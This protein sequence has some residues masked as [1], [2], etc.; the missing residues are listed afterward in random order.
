[1]I[2]TKKATYAEQKSPLFWIIM[3]FLSLFLVISPYYKGLFNGSFVF[4]ERSLY[5]TFI[6]A[7]IALFSV[8]LYVF[9]QKKNGCKSQL[10]FSTIVWLIPL[11]YVISMI[12]AKS[13][14]FGMMEIYLHITYAVFF[15]IGLYFAGNKVGSLILQAS[16]FLSSYA[17]VLYGLMNWLGFANYQ[18]AVLDNRLSGVFQYPN[19]YSGYLIGILLVCLIA[20]KNSKK[21]YGIILNG[22]MLGPIFLS[23]WLTLSRGGLF[24][25]PIV[26][27]IYL[28][29]I[30]WRQQLASLCYLAISGV[31]SLSAV[32][33]MTNLRL[34]IN[35]GEDI[36]TSINGCL[37]I[38]G[39]SVL[40]SVLVFVIQK[41]VILPWIQKYSSNKVFVPANFIIPGI[42]VVVGLISVI[43]L[44]GDGH[45]TKL[46]PDGL[47]TRIERINFDDRS[48]ASR[49]SYIADSMKIFKDYPLL[50][51]GGG[52]WASLY[53]EY[54]SFPYT[55]QQTHTF[56]LKYLI[57]TGIL[58]CGIFVFLVILIFV[59]YVRTKM[60]E[61]H[62]MSA[63]LSYPVLS[64]A[65]LV[66][67][68]IDFDM[69]FAYL[70]SLMFLGLGAM[71]S[72][73]H[74]Q[75]TFTTLPSKLRL[76]NRMF[77]LFLAVVALFLFV[78]GVKAI[79]AN[80][81]Y[82]R[83]MDI[84]NETGAVN[85]IIQPLD[86]AIEAQS[87][88]TYNLFKVDILVQLY[89]HTQDEQY[90]NEALNMLKVLEK[91]ESYNREMIEL[92]Y[93]LLVARREFQLALDW[94]ERNLKK[95]PWDIN[96]YE[97][98]IS[99]NYELG[100]E[101]RLL[102]T[103][104][105]KSEYWNLAFSYL[106]RINKKNDE[107]SMLSEG[108]RVYLKVTPGIAL[109]IGQ[110]HYLQG[111]Y[112]EAAAIMEPVLSIDFSNSMNRYI[113]RWYLASIMKQNKQDPMLY[114]ALISEYPSEEQ[115]L[116]T[117]LTE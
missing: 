17:I 113:I 109:S 11:S 106:E 1:M 110:I 12:N 31:I 40:V 86:A 79:K 100:N 96:L 117:M 45:L 78:S 14:H 91:N 18:D 104:D 53:N 61:A 82:V 26:L 20:I 36:Y 37:L 16:L 21:W 66:H 89:N 47:K 115:E 19:T 15:L 54:K 68:S 93:K 77:P 2:K 84:A 52:G 71:V 30:P 8:A 116:E 44:L 5:F 57:E 103:D 32:N 92:K 55:S 4:F 99:L 60:K 38:I 6:W 102:N 75:N 74:L 62:L 98:A 67:S 43:T 83:A 88:P 41:F 114:D 85:Q 111:N 24:I 49:G 42:L 27:T 70:S 59:K 72:T 65:I 81:L 101:A 3:T 80:N 10:I 76:V 69:S 58:G 34:F 97:K 23:F 9:V 50:G 90:A 13:L 95:Y 29:L 64:I 51:T 105:I 46:L 22:L 28:F 107:V 39:L 87:H 48:I 7:S 108:Q 112:R 73:S 56:Y 35:E 63:Q 25:L 94:V 33:Y